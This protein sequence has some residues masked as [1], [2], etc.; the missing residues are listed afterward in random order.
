MDQRPKLFFWLD[1]LI[2]LVG[3]MIVG[4][5]LFNPQEA[6]TALETLY[7]GAVTCNEVKFAY[8]AGRDLRRQLL[9]CR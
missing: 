2:S 5:R 4:E 9:H 1:L 7:S 3:L 8:P 6:P